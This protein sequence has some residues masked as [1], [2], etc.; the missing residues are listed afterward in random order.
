MFVILLCFALS[1]AQQPPEWE[2]CNT[3]PCEC[4]YQNLGWSNEVICEDVSIEEIF[5]WQ[6][7][8]P[9]LDRLVLDNNG[10][11][12]F[13]P[14][15]FF[16]KRLDNLKRLEITSNPLLDL[17]ASDFITAPYLQEL[18]IYDSELSELP[19]DLLMHIRNLQRLTLTFNSK[20]I[21]LPSSLL[22]GLENLTSISIGS[23][24]ALKEIPKRFLWGPN[25]PLF[26]SFTGSRVLTSDGIPYDLVP[27]GDAL[28][29]FVLT[30][31]TNVTVFK[32]TWLRYVNNPH[33]LTL[34]LFSNNLQFIERGAFDGIKSRVGQILLDRNDLSAEGIPHDIF[35]SIA[36]VDRPV[37]IDL[38]NNPRLTEMPAACQ[39]EGVTCTI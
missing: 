31:H 15:F 19:E 8:P 12:S 26:V 4:Y 9:N 11:N 30:G 18:R 3:G 10:M 24:H 1:A 2:L 23:N 6:F 22:Y 25:H 21:S 5:L 13:P 20:L 37:P 32:N 35:D 38:T 28:V 14:N 39:I 29:H 36:D 7:F 17:Q 33:S 27:N 34:Y 16:T